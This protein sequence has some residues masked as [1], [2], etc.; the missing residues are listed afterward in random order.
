MN[1]DNRRE[2]DDDPARLRQ[3]L[4]RYQVGAP[5]PVIEDEL[6]ETFRRR[7]SWQRSLRR[8]AVAAVVLLA[9][10]ALLLARRPT[11][12]VNVIADRAAAP[13]PAT[14]AV[15]LVPPAPPNTPSHEPAPTPGPARVVAA[16]PRQAAPEVQVEPG[17][18]EM[19][20]QFAR[21]VRTVP[22]AGSAVGEDVETQFVETEKGI[23]V[24][25]PVV[26]SG[27]EV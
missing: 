19:L 16:R 12:P 7:V 5:P 4:R 8:L 26:K 25:V 1:R 9:L 20:R 14:P 11:M 17:Q 23:H 2:P 18:L 27:G 24:A 22:E 13:P 15:P 3:I 6:R 10:G 21:S